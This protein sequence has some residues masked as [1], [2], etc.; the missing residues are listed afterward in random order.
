MKWLSSIRR[1][2]QPLSRD[3]IFGKLQKQILAEKKFGHPSTASS[4]RT[5]PHRDLSQKRSY[6]AGKSVETLIQTCLGIPPSRTSETGV[7]VRIRLRCAGL[8]EPVV[9][10]SH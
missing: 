10:E 7:W 8:K 5:S 1:V 6:L 3:G 4:S 9:G 2:L